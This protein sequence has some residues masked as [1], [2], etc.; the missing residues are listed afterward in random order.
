MASGGVFA[1]LANLWKG[2]L[3]LWVAD[4]EKEQPEIA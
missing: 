2:F 3:S 1:R 4:L